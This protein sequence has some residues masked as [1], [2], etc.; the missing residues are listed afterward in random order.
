LRSCPDDAVVTWEAAGDG[1]ALS[2]RL[3]VRQFPGTGHAMVLLASGDPV[4]LTLRAQPHEELP[5]ELA[6]ALSIWTGAGPCVALR[7]LLGAAARALDLPDAADL[8]AQLL[9]WSR[10]TW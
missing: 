9:A 7:R 6:Q 3:L 5:A 1:A 10:S 4:T 8:E 2:R